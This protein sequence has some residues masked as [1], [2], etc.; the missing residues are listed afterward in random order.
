M[1]LFGIGGVYKELPPWASIVGG[2]PCTI[3]DV[4]DC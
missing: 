3:L 1:Q 2:V 4:M